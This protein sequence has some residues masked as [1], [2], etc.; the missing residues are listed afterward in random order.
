MLLHLCQGRLHLG[1]PEGH[2]QVAIERDGGRQL[3]AGPLSMAYLAVQPSQPVVA[4]GEQFL[5]VPT[6]SPLV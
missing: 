2:V 5:P 3:S 4:A 1:Q 6:G